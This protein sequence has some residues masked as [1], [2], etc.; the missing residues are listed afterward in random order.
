MAKA[1]LFGQNMFPSVLGLLQYLP[2][3]NIILI[4]TCPKEYLG[5]ILLEAF[6]SH[7]LSLKIH[8]FESSLPYIH[9]CR[10]IP[11][12]K[13]VLVKTSQDGFH[14]EYCTQHNNS[15]VLAE[16]LPHKRGFLK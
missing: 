12:I 8:V 13:H 11:V 15:I 2:E 1:Q 4:L 7:I 6:R 5:T 16:K 14:V 9:A 10:L 3:Q